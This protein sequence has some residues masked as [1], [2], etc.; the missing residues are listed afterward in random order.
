MNST[1]RICARDALRDRRSW[2]KITPLLFRPG[3]GTAEKRRARQRRKTPARSLDLRRR[4]NESRSPEDWLEL[5]LAAARNASRPP[6]RR[7]AVKRSHRTRA[8]HAQRAIIDRV[9]TLVATR[10]RLASVTADLEAAASHQNDRTDLEIAAQQIVDLQKRLA[11]VTDRHQTLTSQHTELRDR[12]AA[13]VSDY[14]KAVDRL[15]DSARDRQRFRPVIEAWDTP[16]RSSREVGQ[17]D[18]PVRR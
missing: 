3:V 13:L 8:R 9:H 10:D 14:N 2:R 7:C 15:N 18:Y 1:T 11:T 17:D 5:R 12:Y 6:A 16:G 4:L